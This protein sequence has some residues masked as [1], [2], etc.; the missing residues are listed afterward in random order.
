MIT[1]TKMVVI[2]NLPNSYFLTLSLPTKEVF[3][4]N[5]KLGQWQIFQLSIFILSWKKCQHQS[6][7]IRNF[8]F[9][10]YYIGFLH[11]LGDFELRCLS[12]I[13]NFLCFRHHNSRKLRRTT[14]REN[15]ALHSSTWPSGA[16]GEWRV[17][18]RLNINTLEKI[19]YTC[20]AT[21]FTQDRKSL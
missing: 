15:F 4:V 7:W 6:H 10:F 14:S 1:K 2:L 11:L 9:F 13:R 16:K 12:A 21:A 18:S 17:S 20:V 19:R 3:Q 8:R 5:G